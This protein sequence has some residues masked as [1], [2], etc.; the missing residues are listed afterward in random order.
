MKT[1][2]NFL[3]TPKPE[4]NVSAISQ[5]L[6]DNL[7]IHAEADLTDKNVNIVGVLDAEAELDNHIEQLKEGWK[8]EFI[9]KIQESLSKGEPLQMVLEK[10]SNE[11]NV[12]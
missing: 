3:Q 6:N 10:I 12:I 1:F 11:T 5:I 4:T 7:S 9:N 2:T 8:K